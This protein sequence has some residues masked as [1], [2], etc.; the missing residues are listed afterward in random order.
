MKKKLMNFVLVLAVVCLTTVQV[1]VG[2]R[3]DESTINV[4][5]QRHTTIDAIVAVLDQFTASTG[6]KVTYEILPQEQVV[7]RPS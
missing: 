3:S 7:Q 6:I 5:L 4:V 2:G 1:F